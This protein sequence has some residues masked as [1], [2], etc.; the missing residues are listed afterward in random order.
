MEICTNVLGLVVCSFVSVNSEVRQVCRD[1]L[2]LFSQLDV[3][4]APC[5]PV[6]W[7]AL[8]VTSSLHLICT[9]FI[10]VVTAAAIAV[11]VAVAIA[12]A[13]AIVTAVVIAVAI[14]IGNEF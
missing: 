2:A 8:R 3:L 5:T 1:G 10:I 13:T 14:V 12:V 7:L 6:A 4:P 11:T 9:L